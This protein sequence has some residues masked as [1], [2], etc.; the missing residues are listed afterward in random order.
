MNNEPIPTIARRDH[1]E[2]HARLERLCSLLDN[3]GLL[4]LTNEDRRQASLDIR[5]ML[6]R[7][8]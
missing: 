2:L 8:R 5:L 3:N 7:D 6:R 1:D 4:H